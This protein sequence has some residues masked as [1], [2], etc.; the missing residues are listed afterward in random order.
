MTETEI[1]KEIKDYLEDKGY[2]VYRMN[3]GR[4]RY[5]IRMA[6]PGTPDLLVILNNGQSIWIEVKQP[7]LKCT[8]IQKEMHQK[9]ID[10][11]QKVMVAYNKDDVKNI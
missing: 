4:G 10:K 9:L 1:Q 7:G 2:L 5:N 8:D 6:P 11:G 3:S